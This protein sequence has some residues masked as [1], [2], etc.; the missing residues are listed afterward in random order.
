MKKSLLSALGLAFALAVSLP[1][2]GA[3][4]ADAASLHKKHHYHHHHNKHHR[5]HHHQR[6]HNKVEAKKA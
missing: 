5:H 3:S 4:S 2:I 1:L 6:H